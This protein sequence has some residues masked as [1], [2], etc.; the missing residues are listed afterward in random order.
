[1]LKNLLTT[2]D[3]KSAGTPGGFTL[4]ETPGGFTLLETPGGFPLLETPGY[5]GAFDPSS[6]DII[7]TY[8]TPS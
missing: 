7:R 1:M 5:F 4:L 8:D 2:Y 3:F 6:A